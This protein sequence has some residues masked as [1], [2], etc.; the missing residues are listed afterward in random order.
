[1]AKFLKFF[2]RMAKLIKTRTS[3]QIKSHH[4]KM[5]LKHHSFELVL[6]YVE[7]V[8][9]FAMLDSEKTYEKIKKLDE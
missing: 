6:E 2:T 5:M 8:V 3:H 7:L 9:S 1:M 4:Q